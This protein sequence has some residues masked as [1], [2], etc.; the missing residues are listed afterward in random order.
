ML[1]YTQ[2]FSQ[3]SEFLIAFKS[4]IGYTDLITGD[5]EV[6]RVFDPMIRSTYCLD[7]TYSMNRFLA[8]TTGVNFRKK[9][10]QSNTDLVDA[11]GNIVRNAKTFFQ[12]NFITL[13]IR[14]EFQSGKRLKFSFGVGPFVGLRLKSIAD[15]DIA[16]EGGNFPRNITA[17][18]KSL[19]LGI[20]TRIGIIYPLNKKLSV[21]FSITDEFGLNNISDEKYKYWGDV[22]THL[23]AAELGLGYSF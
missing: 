1:F 16:V 20:S 10:F 12:H 3:D 18:Y 7:F 4:G 2:S 5:D 21:A 23:I 15:T 22:K 9:G 11:N 19:D 14:A 17:E 6:N 8:I 13:P